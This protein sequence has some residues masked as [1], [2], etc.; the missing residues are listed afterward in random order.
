MK[1]E[2]EPIQKVIDWLISDNVSRFISYYAQI[3]GSLRDLTK[4]NVVL[5]LETEAHES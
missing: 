4:T 1:M 5:Q 2:L 3:V